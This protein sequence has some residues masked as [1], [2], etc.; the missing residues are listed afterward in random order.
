VTREDLEA[1]IPPPV[2]SRGGGAIASR[3]RHIDRVE[4][5]L[6]IRGDRMSARQAATRLGVTPRTIT[7]YRR[8]LREISC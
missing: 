1:A 6:F 5:Y 4:D 8:F 2:R 7:R 3:R